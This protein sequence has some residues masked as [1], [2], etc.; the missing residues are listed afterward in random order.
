MRKFLKRFTALSLACVLIMLCSQSFPAAAAAYSTK[1]EH[2]SRHMCNFYQTDKSIL[3][4]ISTS[5]HPY[6]VGQNMY[7]G[8]LTEPFYKECTV[9]VY[10]Y[11]WLW[12]CDC[13]KTNGYYFEPDIVHEDCGQ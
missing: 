2:S 6:L 8:G 11:R 1:T 7:P 5:T 4:L 9:Y 12:K 13:G 10:L 3:Y